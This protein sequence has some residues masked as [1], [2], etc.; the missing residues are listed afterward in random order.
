MRDKCK[1]LV[2]LLTDVNKLEYEREFAQKT[3]DK[4]AASVTSTTSVNPAGPASG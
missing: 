3:R 2:D 1:Q 4:F